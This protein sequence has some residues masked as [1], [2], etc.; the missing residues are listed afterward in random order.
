MSKIVTIGMNMR[1]LGV[2]NRALGAIRLRLDGARDE[3]DCLQKSL[4][5]E[6]ARVT[7]ATKADTKEAG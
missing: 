2:F 5:N 1:Q 4:D 6:V 7:D 3:L